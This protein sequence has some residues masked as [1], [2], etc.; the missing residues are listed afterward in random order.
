MSNIG[1][2]P[3]YLVRGNDEDYPL[4]FIILDLDGN[5]VPLNLTTYESIKMDIKETKAISSPVV[6]SLTINSGLSINGVNSNILSISFNRNFITNDS[7]R[8]YYDILFKKNSKYKT[9]IGGVISIEKVV[10]I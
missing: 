10:T 3:I 2:L 9:L 8:Y 1:N 7:I 6:L 5:E 4:E